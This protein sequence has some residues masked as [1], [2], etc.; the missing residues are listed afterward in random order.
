MLLDTGDALIGGGILGDR[1]QGEVIVAGM[2]LMGYDA[3]AL[4]PRELSLG[5]DLL[6]QRMEEAQFPML[7]ANVMLSGTE[8]L[9]AQPYV[10]LQIADHR[11][12]IIGLTRVPDEPRA[13][14]QVLDPQEAAARY[15]AEVAGQA[16]TVIVLTNLKY[17][18]ALELASAVPGID[19]MIAALP[20]Q[21]PRQVATAPETGT[22]VVTAE[23]PLSRH[24]GRQVG[25]LAVTI[26]SDGTLSDVS[27][28]IK[29]MDKE[30]PDDPQMRALL[31][32]YRQ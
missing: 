12:G 8:E 26:E 18:R 22:R 4:G 3:M 13:G 10:V 15:V 29:P 16:D 14:F 21:L 6:R 2:S 23:Q 5:V 31:D 20:D 25:R 32:K 24:T 28:T 19:L 17:R 27:W 30:I 7:S 11:V 9:F 1:T